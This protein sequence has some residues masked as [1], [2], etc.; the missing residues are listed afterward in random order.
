MKL[1]VMMDH[2]LNAFLL[3]SLMIREDVN[4]NK[5]DA[6]TKLEDV[7]IV[8]FLSFTIKLPQAV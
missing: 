4:Q 6:F 1:T 5:M 8:L 2:A 3:V 7:N